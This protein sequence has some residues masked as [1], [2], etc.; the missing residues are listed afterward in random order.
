MARYD[1]ES[2]ERTFKSIASIRMSSKDPQFANDA[3]YW[4]GGRCNW[5]ASH[6]L[7]EDCQL[8]ASF[9]TKISELQDVKKKLTQFENQ[10]EFETKKQN[11]SRQCQEAIAR[12]RVNTGAATSFGGVCIIW[13]D[14]ASHLDGIMSAFR[15]ELE[16]L[17]G[18][19][20]R[21]P[22][23]VAKKL[24]KLQLE[25]K[26][27]K[28]TIEE[29]LKRAAMEKDSEKKRKLL[30]L[31]EEDKKKL[32]AN[33][34]EQAKIRIG[35]NFN[36]DRYIEE[37]IKGIEDKLAGRDRSRSGG[38]GDKR[39]PKSPNPNNPDN[40]NG[41]SGESLPPN[42]PRGGGNPW[43]PNQPQNSSQPNQQQLILI[44]GV[45]LVA[46]FLLMSQKDTDRPR[47]RTYDDYY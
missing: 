6:N 28:R 25:E 31:V 34:E 22:Y 19:I 30:I 35:E 15:R 24:K 41:G 3:G 32:Q 12:L 1:A 23:N 33:L 2:I 13:G 40:N 39:S 42:Y 5:G 47:H 36:P 8:L 29:N 9:F 21:T 43:Q 20:S 26:N 7:K 46:I 17:S 16:S 45:F 4:T 10:E 37:F 18:D 44:A 14:Y 38:S 11:L 27:L